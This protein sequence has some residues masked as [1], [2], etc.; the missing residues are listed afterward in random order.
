MDLGSISMCLF[1]LVVSKFPPLEVQPFPLPGGH[2]LFIKGSESQY[3]GTEGEEAV[4]RYFP[5][6]KMVELPGGHF[7]HDES[8]EQFL[9]LVESFLRR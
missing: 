6:Y 9:N 8:E 4:K 3:L 1:N 2:V 7:V 5:N